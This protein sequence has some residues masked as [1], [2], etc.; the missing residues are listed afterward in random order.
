M[1]VSLQE[2]DSKIYLN[3]NRKQSSIGI[4]L[5]NDTLYLMIY[6]YQKHTEF[7]II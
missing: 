2:K 4:L 1:A 6:I 3:T 5:A 7:D